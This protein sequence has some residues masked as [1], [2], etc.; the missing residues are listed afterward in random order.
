M[1]VFPLIVQRKLPARPQ[2]GSG[3]SPERPRQ[4]PRE[5]ALP[6]RLEDDADTRGVPLP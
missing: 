1:M 3:L 6:A 5:A 4:A 2:P